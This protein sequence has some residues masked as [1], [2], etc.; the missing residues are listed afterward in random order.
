MRAPRSGCDEV[1][2]VTAQQTTVVFADIV[3]STALY[4]AMGNE[5]AALAVTELLNDM[6]ARVLQQG[7]RV[8]KTLGDGILCVFA[9]PTG[10]V[11]SMLQI[12][13]EQRE[14]I[15]LP[16]TNQQLSLRIGIA[17]GEVLDVAGDC[18]G[19]AVNTAARLCER[20]AADEIWATDEVVRAS[21]DSAG[22][23]FVRLGHLKVRGK[24][25]P[26]LMYQIEW[27]ADEAAEQLTL[28]GGLTDLGALQRQ[29][30]A[31]IQFSWGCSKQAFVS[32]DLP[33][34]VGRASDA[35]LY[36]EDPR[37]SRLHARIDWHDGAFMLT[38]LSSFG[39]WVLFEGSD[40]PVQL[41]RDSCMLHGGGE[42]A[43]S[44]PFSAPDAPRI[45]FRISGEKLKFG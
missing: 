6:S 27:R 8:V 29:N 22:A 38:D 25:E 41:R 10:A 40:T 44:L 16:V 15:A 32:S 20:A 42:L 45:A 24:A 9:E 39:T 1:S 33:I 30:S 7:G 5:R 28:H 21:S 37:V 36:L 34:H 14:R 2:Q 19:D 23:L 31:Q 13:R 12:M 4:E 26:L 35:H 3:G 11:R 43:L 18:Y 17:S